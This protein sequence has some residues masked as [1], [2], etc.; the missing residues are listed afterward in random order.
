MRSVGRHRPFLGNGRPH[1]RATASNPTR[2]IAVAYRNLPGHS[3]GLRGHAGSH[4]AMPRHATPRT[5]FN[6]VEDS[7]A[8]S[9]AETWYAEAVRLDGE[10]SAAAVDAYLQCAI[11]AWPTVEMI[12]GGIPIAPDLNSPTDTASVQDSREWELYHYAVA[13]LLTTAQ[14]FGR[15]SPARRYRGRGP[16]RQFAFGNSLP[17]LPLGARQF[18]TLHV[19]DGPLNTPARSPRPRWHRRAVIRAP[20]RRRR[21]TAILTARPAICRHRVVYHRPHR[22]RAHGATRILRSP[23]RVECAPRRRCP[24][25]GR[26]LGSAGP[27]GRKRSPSLARAL[28]PSR[29]RRQMATASK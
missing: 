20:Q 13:G 10:G 29:E 8:A 5:A 24:A 14:K 26:H 6:L 21:N 9:L 19:A 17:G 15:W 3:A 28:S 25:G 12:A 22:K 2:E 4:L 27:P 18:G 11:A 1:R 7:A 16:S 23:T